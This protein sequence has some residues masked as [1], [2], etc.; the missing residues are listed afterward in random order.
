M[1]HSNSEFSRQ[2]QYYDLRVCVSQWDV[3]AAMDTLAC[4]RPDRIL[5]RSCH[6][7]IDDPQPILAQFRTLLWPGP[8][9]DAGPGLPLSLHIYRTT[10]SADQMD[11]VRNLGSRSRKYWGAFPGYFRLAAAVRRKLISRCC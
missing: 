5:G 4:A 8:K 11:C 7:P 3:C 6:S 10:A 1:A 9:Y 2:R